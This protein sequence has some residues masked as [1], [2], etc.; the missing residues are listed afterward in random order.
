M[1]TISR[2][3][4]VRAEGAS[5]LAAVEEAR[6]DRYQM[7]PSKVSIYSTKS[8]QSVDEYK[9]NRKIEHPR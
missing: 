8:M 4:T 7:P 6:F 5:A 3:T 1:T 2:V 9:G